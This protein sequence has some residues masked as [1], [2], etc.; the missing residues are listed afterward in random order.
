MAIMDNFHVL[1]LYGIY[2]S[3]MLENGH[4]FSCGVWLI[5]VLLYISLLYDCVDILSRWVV[6]IR[7]VVVSIEENTYVI[8]KIKY[9]PC[10]KDGV[11]CVS[12]VRKLFVIALGGRT[13]SSGILCL[14]QLQCN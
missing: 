4:G 14:Y 3:F 1:L 12:T 10:Y 7:F 8:W 5:F 2:F 9:C 13:G 6:F 11:Q